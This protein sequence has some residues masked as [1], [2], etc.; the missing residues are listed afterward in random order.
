MIK[1]KIDK[2][3]AI[4]LV[5]SISLL[6]S[7]FLFGC[8]KDSVDNTLV[9]VSS[10][11]NDSSISVT[12]SNWSTSESLPENTT[13]SNPEPDI[14]VCVYKYLPMTAS[15]DGVLDSNPDRGFRT[16]FV[17]YIVETEE[18]GKTYDQRTAFADQS[19]EEIRDVL[20]FVFR[21]Y[22]KKN[23]VP[24]N[25]LFLAYIYIT[26]YHDKELTQNALR[27]MEIFF[28][29]CR[30]RNVKCMLRMCYNNSYNKNFNFSEENKQLL[31]S[32]CAD[33]ETI[34]KH[35]KQLKPII[36][37]YSDAIHTISSGF[38]G[39]VGEWAYN[40]QYP[41]VDYAT[42]IKAIVEELCV[43]NDLFFSIR[44][45]AYKEKV[46]SGY[47]YLN[48]ISHNNDAM[49]GEQTIDNW[50]SGCYQL[51]HNGTK[52]ETRCGRRDHVA[53]TWWEDVMKSGAYTPQDG[54]MYTNSSLLNYNVIPSGLQII[55]ECAHHRHTSMSNCHG[56]LDSIKEDSSVMKRWI[57]N[58]VVTPE[59]LDKNN[60]IYDPNWFVDDN[61]KTVKRNPYEFL[62]DHLGYK[63][64]A[65]EGHLT[66]NVERNSQV[67]FE[68]KLKNY[69]FAAVFMLE[70]GFVILDNY[71]D[72]VASVKT[73]EPDK[74]YSH[75]P[76]N[77]Q[78]TEVLEHSVKADL[79]LPEK[80][81]KYYIAFYLK[82]TM[83]DYARLSNK[84]TYDNGYA[85]LCEINI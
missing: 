33:Q 23:V 35:I 37:E 17:F 83:E 15:D 44:S 59:I 29:V 58:E 13:E 67:S 85:I 65:T 12:E 22:F 21:I 1:R 41:I 52:E 79:T 40:Y 24:S 43:P 31:A 78:S 32:E 48:H 64:V 8:G 62:K 5:L 45:P 18:A 70:S 46:D 10:M 63:L 60:I 25:K 34:L 38:V 47:K 7:V 30:E 50:H 39:Y 54:E 76:E 36:F 75:D 73:G 28:E 53:N 71:G 16:H 74:W 56:Y 49:H 80:S 2:N 69:G 9:N 82:N 14:P 77:Y 6:F 51:G 19:E 27:V 42:V 81:G 72:V 68:L 66:G 4:V 3:K 26:D 55:L 20:D 57:N 84:V 61:G 11:D